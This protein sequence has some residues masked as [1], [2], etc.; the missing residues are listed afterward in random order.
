MKERK[1]SCDNRKYTSCNSRNRITGIM[2][3]E[4]SEVGGMKVKAVSGQKE[5]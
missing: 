5:P 3:A 2:K 1:T 4:G